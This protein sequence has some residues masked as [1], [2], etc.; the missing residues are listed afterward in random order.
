MRRFTGGAD[1]VRERRTRADVLADLSA[2]GF[3][4]SA[5]EPHAHAAA[6]G[7]PHPSTWT[8]MVVFRARRPG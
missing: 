3:E 5:I 8:R 2:A 6:L 1:F 4:A 7:L